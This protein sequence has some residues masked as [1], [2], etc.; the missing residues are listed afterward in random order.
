LVPSQKTIRS[1]LVF[2][3]GYGPG[4]DTSIFSNTTLPASNNFCT[5]VQLSTKSDVFLSTNLLL[6]FNNIF[7]AY[8]TVY[9]NCVTAI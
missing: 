7:P 9:L 3:G 5:K 8:R 2:Q 6:V 1:L 4:T